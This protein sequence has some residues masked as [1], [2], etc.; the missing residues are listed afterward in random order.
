MR[1]AWSSSWGLAPGYGRYTP[2]SVVKTF[3]SA[4]MNPSDAKQTRMRDQIFNSPGGAPA[5]LPPCGFFGSFCCS[6]RITRARPT[7]CPAHA[8]AVGGTSRQCLRAAVCGRQV[9]S[10]SRS[11]LF[12]VISRAGGCSDRIELPHTVASGRGDRGRPL[13]PRCPR[14]GT[15]VRQRFIPVWSSPRPLLEST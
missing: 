1:V 12:C 7:R 8:A 5:A 6:G 14:T 15:P 3:N 2:A 11:C 4:K 13:G 9:I 10:S